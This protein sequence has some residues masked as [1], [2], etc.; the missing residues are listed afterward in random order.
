MELIQ[1]LQNIAFELQSLDSWLNILLT[2]SFIGLSGA[3]NFLSVL[4]I[5]VD[6]SSH[7]FR[8][9]GLPEDVV[10]SEFWLYDE[11]PSEFELHPAL[12]SALSGFKV[13][14]K[15]CF[16]CVSQKT[17]ENTQVF[18]SVTANSAHNNVI[19]RSNLHL[20]LVQVV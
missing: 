13:I 3:T 5:S 15:R 19:L 7:F 20:F 4:T 2:M 9:N 10:V 6:C 8:T 14:C 17:V 12:I 11:I 1:H 18:I 16:C